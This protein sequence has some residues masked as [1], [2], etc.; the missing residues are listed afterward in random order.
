MKAS[1]HL[2]Y[3]TMDTKCPLIKFHSYVFKYSDNKPFF[4]HS[5]TIRGLREYSNQTLPHS[6]HDYTYVFLH[7]HVLTKIRCL[8]RTYEIRMYDDF[9]HRKELLCALRLPLHVL[10][11]H[12][13]PVGLVWEAIARE[14]TDTFNGTLLQTV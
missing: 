9:L 2:F 6:R 11:K 12:D 4:C 5:M 7:K 3:W 8:R 10:T 13:A 14:L 1:K